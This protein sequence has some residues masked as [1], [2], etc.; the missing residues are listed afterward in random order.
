MLSR[1]FADFGLG[2]APG[3]PQVGVNGGATY[4]MLMG[5]RNG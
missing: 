5:R 3:A 2:I 4:T 1:S